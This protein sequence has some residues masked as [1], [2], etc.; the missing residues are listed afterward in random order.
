[1]NSFL[2]LPLIPREV[3]IYF[4]ALKHNVCHNDAHLYH[5]V[6]V[7]VFVL[8]GIFVVYCSTILSEIALLGKQFTTISPEYTYA[9][10]LVCAE[11]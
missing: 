11:F 4:I 10:L 3:K 6:T 8:W 1:M 7:M 9:L 2:T 5:A